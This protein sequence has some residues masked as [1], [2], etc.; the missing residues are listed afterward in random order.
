MFELNSTEVSTVYSTGSVVPVVLD[1]AVDESSECGIEPLETDTMVDAVT[2]ISENNISL[3]EENLVPLA[4]TRTTEIS[5]VTT[6]TGE[7]AALERNSQSLIEDAQKTLHN[8]FTVKDLGQLRYFL[9]IEILRL[10]KG[11]L[12]NQRNFTLVLLS[13]VGLSGAKPVSTP[14]ELNTKLTTIKKATLSNNNKI[15]Q[16]CPNT[17]RSITGYVIML[18][19]SMVSWKSKKQHTVSRS[20]VEAEYKSMAGAV[21]EI[22]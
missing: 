21:S 5:W 6:M 13:T 10:D 15:G 20:S 8:G 18:G 14:M 7:I 16:H 1:T 17:R 12:L 9:G 22:I 4:D 3:N 11:I 19:E 2:K